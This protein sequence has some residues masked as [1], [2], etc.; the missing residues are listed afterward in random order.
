MH[1]VNDSDIS[2]MVS[3]LK[4]AGATDVTKPATIAFA[5]QTA[6]ATATVDGSTG[7]VTYV[8]SFEGVTFYDTVEDFN[9]A[10]QP[11]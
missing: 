5:D 8:T 11:A 7:S 1:G 3:A 10:Q 6:K 9:K 4:V 2:A